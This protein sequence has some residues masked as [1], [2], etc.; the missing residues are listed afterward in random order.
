MLQK[1][2]FYVKICLA[3]EKPVNFIKWRDKVLL[4][5]YPPQHFS[6]VLFP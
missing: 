2:T 5:F 4:T 6:V 3:F 1:L